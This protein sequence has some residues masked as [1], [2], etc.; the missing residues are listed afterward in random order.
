MKRFRGIIF[1]HLLLVWPAFV[2]AMDLAVPEGSRLVLDDV[3]NDSQYDV[4]VAA[5]SKGAVPT[6]R[7]IGQ[8]HRQVWRF[9]KSF[10]SP[11]DVI[12]A[13]RAQLFQ[14]GFRPLLDCDN[15]RCGGFDFRFGIDVTPPPDM[16]VDLSDYHFFSAMRPIPEGVEGVSILVSKSIDA[17]QMEIISVSPLDVKKQN[18]IRLSPPKVTLPEPQGIDLGGRLVSRGVVSLSD[19][20]FQTGS[21]ELGEGVFLS[22]KEL[23]VFLNG[24]AART[25][26][27]VGHTDNEGALDKNIQLSKRRAASVL[28]RLVADYDVSRSQIAAHGV[29]YLS[30]VGSNAT[31]DGRENNR[32]VEAVLLTR[33]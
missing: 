10:L 19:L 11:R 1:A 18:D 27:L 17:G 28:E 8:V 24:N 31:A 21:S 4:P 13:M 14:Q 29:G 6:Q 25:V 16:F 9:D 7:M 30:P 23:S 3:K 20:T 15:K 32:R 22:L 12:E 5:F 2:S 26:A 33:E